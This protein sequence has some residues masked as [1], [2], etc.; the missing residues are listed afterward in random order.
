MKETVAVLRREILAL[1]SCLEKIRLLKDAVTKAEDA[2]S[3]KTLVKDAETVM[4]ELA[5]AANCKDNFLKDRKKKNIEEFLEAQELQSEKEVVMRLL[6]KTKSL[7]KE[8]ADEIVITKE[9]LK[10]SNAFVEFHINVM[11]SVKADTTYGP[12]GKNTGDAAA[13]KM[14][15]ANV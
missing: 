5:E 11:A 1:N 12:P 3:V 9:L 15:D 8:F 2:T 10:R 6:N 14:F 4:T 13:K 7:E